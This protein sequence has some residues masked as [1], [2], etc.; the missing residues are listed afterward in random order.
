MRITVRFPLGVY[1]AQ[2]Q[3]SFEPEWP[4]HPVRLIGAL[5]AAAHSPGRLGG[6]GGSLPQDL[7]LLQKL[8]DASPPL[9]GAPEA[10]PIGA[11][12]PED[13]AVL[14][15]GATRWAPRNYFTKGAREQAGVQKVGVAIGDR[16]VQ[17]VWPTLDLDPPDIERLSS[18]ASDMS[19]LGTTRSPVVAQV[20]SD[21]SD[22]SDPAWTPVKGNDA[23][24]APVVAVRVP[25]TTTLKAFDRRHE[26]RRSSKTGVEAAT[27]AVPGIRI[28]REVAYVHSSALDSSTK[29]IDPHWWGDMIVLA[30]DREK[31]EVIPRAGASYLLA[32]AVRT[33]LLS[34]YEPAGETDEA[35]AILRGRGAE[36]HCAIVPLAD[37]WHEGTAGQIKGV[38]V[39]LPN[40]QRTDDL[41]QQRVAIEQG[42]GNL[43]GDTDR[44][45]QRY[46]QIPGAGRIWLRLPTPDEA[47]LK[48]LLKRTYRAT[49][50]SWLSV[51]PVVHA[52]W[53]KGPLETL[54]DQV[55]RDCAHVGLPGPALAEAIRGSTFPGAASRPVATDRVPEAWRKSLGG[56]AGHLRVTFPSPVTGP[57]LLGRARHFGLGL[58]V[59]E[60]RPG[61]AAGG[62]RHPEVS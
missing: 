42:L 48:T 16:P 55:A 61:W 20:A 37:V 14:V 25:E 51:T 28:G 31:S 23:Q 22:D 33:A 3:G 8:C 40:A 12:A 26:A 38:G 60:R 15:T 11:D 47:A 5:V 54:I 46:V 7:A 53:R 27:A 56:P 1:H 41:P 17:F 45:R 4:P 50:T 6:S 49:A 24:G 34:A 35:P 18:L 21:A 29:T 36:A 39:L 58:F 44:G 57:L 10:V 2:S 19:F 32:R 62:Q 43:V 13:E 9:I 52:R 59:P 30:V